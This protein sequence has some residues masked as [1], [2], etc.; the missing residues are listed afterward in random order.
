MIGVVLFIDSHAHLF[1]EEFDSD[2]EQV[3]VNA[4]K[5]G[6]G[7]IVN[8]GIDAGSSREAVRLSGLFHG[9]FATAGIHPQSAASADKNAVEQIAELADNSA[10]VAIGEIGLDYY[11]GEEQKDTQ[12]KTFEEML[13][14]ARLKCL[15]VVLHCRAAEQDMLAVVEKWTRNTLPARGRWHGIRHCFGEDLET[16]L[17]YIDMGFMLSFGAYIG[18]P[19]S[20]KL[21]SV[22]AQL[23]PDS[24]LLETDCP[25]LPPQKIRGKRNDPSYLPITA[26][27][28]AGIRETTTLEIAR[29]TTTNARAI[30]DLSDTPGTD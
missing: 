23:P 30:F 18:Y 6:V 10:I 16:A 17:R 24:F 15:P 20:K 28:I 26:E 4:Q 12:L 14:I 1:L 2:R 22:L 19:S 11:R 5:A 29:Q 9:L 3:I 21:L 27:I 8:A 25:Y 13:D 7:V